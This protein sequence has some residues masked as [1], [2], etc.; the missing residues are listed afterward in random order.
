MY[1]CV[2]VCGFYYHLFFFTFKFWCTYATLGS[3]EIFVDWAI[4]KN[5]VNIRAY[6]I[7]QYY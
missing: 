1:K 6:R 5:N 7:L 2:S 4:P 3:N